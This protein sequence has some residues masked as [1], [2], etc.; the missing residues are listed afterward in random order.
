MTA[1]R[2]TGTPSARPARPRRSPFGV[3]ALLAG[4]LMTIWCA[5]PPPIGIGFDVGRLATNWSRGQQ[6][7]GEVLSP[8]AGAVI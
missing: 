5:L 7:L 8:N 2:A 1:V 3:L 6:I 4:M